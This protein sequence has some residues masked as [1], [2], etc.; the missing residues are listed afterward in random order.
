M[1]QPLSI[2]TYVQVIVEFD[3]DGTMHPTSIL[4]EDGMH[5]EIDRI[6][7]V[8]SASAARAGGQGDRY[9]IRLGE[10]ITY[11]FFDHNVDFG[12]HIPVRWFV[13]RKA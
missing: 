9:T 4:W 5:Y 11:L 12:S 1:A 13:L 8:R 10:Q 3:P 6:L 2:K 7:D